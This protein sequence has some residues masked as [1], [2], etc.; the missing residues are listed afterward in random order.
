M[1]WN[2]SGRGRR[3][4]DLDQNGYVEQ[5]PLSRFAPRHQREAP[6]AAAHDTLAE[7]VT[8]PPFP[9]RDVPATPLNQLIYEGP[10][11]SELSGMAAKPVPPTTPPANQNY[12]SGLEEEP[13]ISVSVLKRALPDRF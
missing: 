1:V 7:P 5:T 8:S 2:L 3:G 13:P 9:P 4:V 11:A 12:L 10:S 6:R